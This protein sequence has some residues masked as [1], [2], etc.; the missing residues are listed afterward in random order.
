[1]FRDLASAQRC[2]YGAFLRFGHRAICCASP[3]LFFARKGADVTVRPMKGTAPR[4]RTLEEDEAERRALI[5]SP[6]Q[7]AENVMVVDM[8]R[9]DL[10]RIAESGSVDVP[11]LFVA[12]RY[13][14]VWQMTSTVRARTAAPLEALVAALHPPAS[15]T[16]APKVRTAQIIKSLEPEPRGVYTGAIGHIAPGGSVQFSVA[17]RTTTIDE[18]TGQLEFGVGS[19]IVSD[20][21]ATDEYGECLLK[22][23]VLDHRATPFELLET[24][25]WAPD[26]GF[27][28]LDRHLRRLRDSA[29]YFGFACDLPR[30]RDA[31]DRAVASAAGSLRLRLLVAQ[32]GSVRIEQTSFDWTGQPLRIGIAADPIDPSDAF[33]FHKTTN[34]TV[35]ER[36]RRAEY[37]ETVLW[38]PRREVTEAITANIVAEIGGRRVTPPVTCGLLAGTFRAEQVATGQVSERPITLDEFYASRRIWLIN[39]VHGWRPAMLSSSGR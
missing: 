15:V 32:D 21:D 33:L 24:L 20:S 14:N 23:S 5:S 8:M 28:L 1:L 18:E 35:Y 26:E 34:R 30:V 19:G 17:I 12:E 36:V 25:R 3:E 11:A 31:L 37:D 13:P 38:N 9:N 39:S 22:A 7:R 16:G 29:D 4:G 2:R 10:G 6:K 27:V